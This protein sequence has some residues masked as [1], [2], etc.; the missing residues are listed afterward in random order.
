MTETRNG[1]SEVVLTVWGREENSTRGVI[2]EMDFRTSLITYID[3][4]KQ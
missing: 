3:K 1:E 2:T 4:A